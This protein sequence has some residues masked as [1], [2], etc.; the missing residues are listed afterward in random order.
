M[1]DDDILSM[2]FE[3]LDEQIQTFCGS[4]IVNNQIEARIYFKNDIFEVI[5]DD[6]SKLE[7]HNEDDIFKFAEE[8]EG[9]VKSVHDDIE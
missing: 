7:F 2:I 3:S 4:I 5:C 1:P 6:G 8:I 9:E